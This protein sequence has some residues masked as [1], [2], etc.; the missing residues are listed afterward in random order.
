M[1]NRAVP[2]RGGP[3]A[4]RA[5]GA[6]GRKALSPRAEGPAQGALPTGRARPLGRAAGS[7]A[8]GLDARPR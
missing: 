8:P 7:P 3:W 1:N 4:A 6:G 5:A 2:P